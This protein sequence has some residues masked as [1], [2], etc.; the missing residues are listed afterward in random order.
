MKIGEVPISFPTE[1]SLTS[2]SPTRVNV[3][4]LFVEQYT[5]NPSFIYYEKKK[6]LFLNRKKIPRGSRHFCDMKYHST[7]RATGMPGDVFD[8][9][10]NLKGDLLM[11]GDRLGDD[12]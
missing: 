3:K 10:N 11:D 7:K 6:H 5:N 4:F 1:S 2:F 8:P 9:L 12:G